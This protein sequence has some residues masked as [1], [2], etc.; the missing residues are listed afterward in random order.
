MVDI[1]TIAKGFSDR[2]FFSGQPSVTVIV[3]LATKYGLLHYIFSDQ[4]WVVILYIQ[5]PIE[6]YPLL[7]VVINNNTVNQHSIMTYPLN[8]YKHKITTIIDF[9]TQSHRHRHLI[10][11]PQYQIHITYIQK[12]R[13]QIIHKST[14]TRSSTKTPQLDHSQNPHILFNFA[15]IGK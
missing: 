3:H 2:H 8:R 5:Q 6:S 15:H 11:I 4:K 9:Y 12:H 13:R 14:T 7:I 10:C 1:G